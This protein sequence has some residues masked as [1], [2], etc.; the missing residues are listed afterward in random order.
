MRF[1]RNHTVVQYLRFKYRIAQNFGRFGGWY[2]IHQS[3]IT[4]VLFYLCTSTIE[5]TVSTNKS[6]LLGKTID[7]Q[8]LG[9][10]TDCT[11]FLKSRHM[12]IYNRT[13]GILCLLSIVLSL[14]EPLVL[15][16]IPLR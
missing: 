12:F 15:L 6:C 7:I 13:F 16:L 3:F 10:E 8:H 14:T 5:T 9:L 2:P 11:I 1:A 4:N